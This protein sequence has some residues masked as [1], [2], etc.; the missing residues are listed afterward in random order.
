MAPLFDRQEITAA[1]SKRLEGFLAGYR[2]NIALLGPEAVGKTSLLKRLLQEKC[3]QST[4]P[5][6][7]YLALSEEES[8]AEWGA[9]FIETLLNAVVRIQRMD[10]SAHG[11][12][13]LLKFC[14]HS[15]PQTVAS[16]QKILSLSGE[17]KFSE[18]VFDNLWDLPQL[19]TQETGL[20]CL[21][22]LD[23]FHRFQQFRVKEPFKKLGRKIMVQSTTM[24][25]AA[26]S[27]PHV[28]RQ[29]LREGLSLLFGQF[30][31]IEM[32]PLDQASSLKAVR[33]VWTEEKTDPF[34]EHLLVELAQGYSAYLDL[35]L[36]G[37]VGR[38]LPRL[39]E[40]QERVILNL[41]ETQLLDPQGGLRH[42]FESSLRV[43]PANRSRR[44]CLQ[45]LSAV[46]MGYHRVP[47]IA[48]AMERSSSHVTRALKILEQAGLVVKQG[49]FYRIPDRLFRFWMVTAYPILQGTILSDI[50]H[51][52]A[53]FRDQSWSW[54]SKVRDAV[55]RPFEEQVIEL[56]RQWAGELV[57][58][59]GKRILLPKCS[60]IE[61]VSAV[62]NGAAVVA[63][64]KEQAGKSWLLVPWAGSL[65]EA[66]ARQLTQ[67]LS[68]LPF[69]DYRK[70]LVGAYPVEINGRLVLQEA[71][72]RLWDLG[73]F[74]NLLDLYGLARIPLP[75]GVRP[76]VASTVSV[77]SQEGAEP[78]QPRIHRAT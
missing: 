24:Y 60:R 65:E 9:R 13:S 18:E 42:R 64:Q 3:V 50:T 35:L 17:K 2:Q 33:S 11:L 5:V 38:P 39:V 52:R 25:L 55:H 41:L 49:I 20:P 66:Q 58:I 72:I 70:V 59:E 68:R 28:A 62:A 71:R 48:G 22:V 54:M 30:E 37:L 19:V 6:T 75:S 7:V 29:I 23:E 32:G 36:Q 27:Q 44:T 53:R 40:E 15:L 78:A 74:N 26:S 43:L 69:K 4:S 21:L 45:V 77:P 51:M 10:S 57:E 63:H 67:D 46:S 8:L 1:L 31:I 73:V 16:A 61:V 76:P 56:V 14:A 12:P 34:L 47:Q